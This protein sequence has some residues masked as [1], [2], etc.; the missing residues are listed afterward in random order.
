MKIAML[1][2]KGLPGIHGGVEKH[3]EQ[4]GERLALRGHEVTVFCRKFYTPST[5][6]YRGM[7]LVLSPTLHTKHLDATVHTLLG[8]VKAGLGSCDLVHYH[9]IGPASMSFLARAL[10]KPVVATVH[11]LDYLRDKWSPFAKWA[12]RRAESATLLFANRVIAVSRL[13]AQRYQNSNTPVTY[14]PNGVSRPHRVAPDR[15]KQQWGL[16]GRDYFFWAGRFSPEKGLHLLIEAFK[17]LDTDFRLVVAGGGNHTEDYVRQITAAIQSDPRILAPGFIS[18]DLLNELYTN[19]VAF[20]LPSL[21][22]GM[23]VSLLEAMSYGTPCIASDI[24]PCRE[25]GTVNGQPVM[26]FFTPNDPASLATALRGVLAESSD[27]QRQVEIAQQHVLDEY[28]WDAIA[29]K[30]ELE[31]E[32]V[33]KRP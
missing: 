23:P 25:L 1:G 5:Q 32:A 14:I 17:G 12:L 15:I 9:G 21:H 2:L 16:E 10:G 27:R 8:G 30:V 26:D 29:R 18:G 7:E 28:H 20:V 31:Y 11:S 24:G 4:L 33:L 22:E 3:V 13:L 19:A 6:N